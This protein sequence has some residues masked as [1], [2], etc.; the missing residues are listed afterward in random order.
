MKSKTKRGLIYHY[1]KAKLKHSSKGTITTDKN[2]H[3]PSKKY[4]H[5]IYIP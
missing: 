5:Y 1:F 2:E 3:H 4:T